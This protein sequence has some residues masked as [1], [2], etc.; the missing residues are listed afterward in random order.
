MI[1]SPCKWLSPVTTSLTQHL[2]TSS[3][4]NPL[5]DLYLAHVAGRKQLCSDYHSISFPSSTNSM[6]SISLPASSSSIISIRLT[7]LG[8][9][10]ALDMARTSCYITLSSYVFISMPLPSFL[11]IYSFFCFKVILQ[12]HLIATLMSGSSTSYAS[13]ITARLFD[14][15]TEITTYLSL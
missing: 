6:T 2:I 12:K 7:M 13:L 14:S 1:P 15:I 5:L 4:R 3:S 8:C 9:P 10:D 11:R